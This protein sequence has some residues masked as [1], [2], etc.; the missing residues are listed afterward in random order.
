MSLALVA[1]PPFDFDL[2]Y[3]HLVSH[4]HRY[5][6]MH[7]REACQRN[8]ARDLRYLHAIYANQGPTPEIEGMISGPGVFWHYKLARSS[9]RTQLNVLS[10][11]GSPKALA[12]IERRFLREIIARMRHEQ[13][14]VVHYPS[15]TAGQFYL[16]RSI[17]GMLPTH[18]S[19]VIAVS[20][21]VL[22]PMFVSR[23]SAWNL[24]LLHP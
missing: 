12:R 24:E 2:I 3:Q 14:G 16:R 19:C 13:S 23:L 15:R 22:D 10:Q 17:P 8:K 4:N 6:N 18:Q 7:L 9:S 11:R 21:G 20:A 5:R 1:I